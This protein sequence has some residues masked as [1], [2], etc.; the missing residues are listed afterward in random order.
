MQKKYEVP[1]M[2]VTFFAA[3]E[4]LAYDEMAQDANEVTPPASTTAVNP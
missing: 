1:Q 4:A 3:R 2:E